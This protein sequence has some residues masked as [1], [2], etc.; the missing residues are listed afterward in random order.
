MEKLTLVGWPYIIVSC[1]WLGS[2][3]ASSLARLC[4]ELS[5]PPGTWEYGGR[6]FS[7]AAELVAAF[8]LFRTSLGTVK[9]PSCER[10]GTWQPFFSCPG[11]EVK[12]HLQPESWK[13]S[14]RPPSVISYGRSAFNM[15]GL[16]AIWNRLD[17]ILKTSGSHWRIL[18]KWNE[19]ACQQWGR[20]I[21]NKA[22][23]RKSFKRA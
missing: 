19:W 1:L 7:A 17:F 14:S 9:S 12:D 13:G 10:A 18:S 16:Y 6:W 3:S 15:K 8:R 23:C 21:R 22:G 2:C 11:S 20:W 5:L 4:L